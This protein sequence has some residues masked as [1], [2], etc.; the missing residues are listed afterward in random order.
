MLVIFSDC[1][2]METLFSPSLAC[3][4]A[5]KPLFGDRRRENS[6]RG[7]ASAADDDDDGKRMRRQMEVSRWL[8]A[9]RPSE[10]LTRTHKQVFFVALRAE[11]PTPA[12]VAGRCKINCCFS[13]TSAPAA[14]TRRAGQRMASRKRTSDK[15]DRRRMAS[16][17]NAT[18]DIH[19][20][21]MAPLSH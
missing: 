16:K 4:L 2:L 20:L 19:N 9:T 7:Q 15:R 21:M 5:I 3:L 13:S 14:P 6:D 8:A 12:K 17:R 11:F 18:D 1:S 10:T